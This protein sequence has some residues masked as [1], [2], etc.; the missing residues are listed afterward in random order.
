MSIHCVIATVCLYFRRGA[1]P[2]PLKVSDARS[3]WTLVCGTM[4]QK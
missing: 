2:I 4:R 3:K 1:T